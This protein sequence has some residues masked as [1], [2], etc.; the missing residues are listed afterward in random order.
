MTG[1][2]GSDKAR[3]W[4]ATMVCCEALLEMGKREG[5]EGDGMGRRWRAVR[6]QGVWLREGERGGTW[7]C[8]EDAGLLLWA[9]LKEY[10][11]L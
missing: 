7:A 4:G 2:C 11:H 9:G 8:F 10:W 3:R 5:G 1:S 6:K